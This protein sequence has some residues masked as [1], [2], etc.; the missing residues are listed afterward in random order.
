[1]TYFILFL[2]IGL[3]LALMVS[4]TRWKLSK[5]RM[6]KLNY[7]S[8]DVYKNKTVS[9][10]AQLKMGQTLAIPMNCSVF[11]NEQEIHLIPNKFKLLLFMTDFPFSFYRKQNKK[12][13]IHRSEYSE[14]IIEATKKDASVFGKVFEVTIKV[15]DQ[16]EKAEMLRKIK[17][18]R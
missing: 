13:K 6:S 2:I 15:N 9:A 1:M 8:F 18:W 14:I 7:S 3:G 12:I 5:D 11:I 4:S 17:K 10:S 16:E